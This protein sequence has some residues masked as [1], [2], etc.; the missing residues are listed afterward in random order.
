MRFSPAGFFARRRGG[1]RTRVQGERQ[2]RLIA[3]YIAR[4]MPHR[5]TPR[6]RDGQRECDA[7]FRDPHGRGYWYSL[8]DYPVGSK[9]PSR[10]RADGGTWV[11]FQTQTR[12]RAAA[13]DRMI[14]LKHV[15]PFRR[16]IM[17]RT[18]IQARREAERHG[19]ALEDGP[20][21]R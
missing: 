6:W 13:A 4:K 2:L 14:A 12:G 10:V 8:R 3:A 1:F 21:A 11:N 19:L 20:G 9:I 16:I 15:D 7:P 5:P 18:A 17:C